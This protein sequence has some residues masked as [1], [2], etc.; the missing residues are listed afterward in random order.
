MKVKDLCERAS[1]RVRLG[2]REREVLAGLLD[3][4]TEAAIAERLGISPHT[5]HTHVRTL[6]LKL[7]VHNR[8]DLFKD[9]L[10]HSR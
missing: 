5:V 6:Y 4:E 3:G 7:G 1:E 10:S 8:V 9:L 2:K